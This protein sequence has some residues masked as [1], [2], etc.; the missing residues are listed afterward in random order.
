[1]DVAK[2]IVSV[3]G[4]RLAFRRLVAGYDENCSGFVVYLEDGGRAL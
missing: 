1:M 3:F 4:K 2:G